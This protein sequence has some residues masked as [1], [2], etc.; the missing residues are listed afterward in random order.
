MRSESID[1]VAVGVTRISR[2]REVY[3]IVEAVGFASDFIV[4]DIR[5]ANLA[6]GRELGA[7]RRGLNSD[8]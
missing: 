6:V 2:S 5:M 7:L 1:A 8:F 4:E 3:L